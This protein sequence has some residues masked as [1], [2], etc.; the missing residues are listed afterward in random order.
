[1]S[2]TALLATITSPRKG[3]I[4]ISK[5]LN[6]SESTESHQLLECFKNAT[7][8]ELVEAQ[9]SL[10]V[11]KIHSTMQS[12]LQRTFSFL[13]ICVY[14]YVYIYIMYVCLYICLSQVLYT[15]EAPVGINLTIQHEKSSRI[16]KKN[17][18]ECPF[19]T[20]I[21]HIKKFQPVSTNLSLRFFLS[22]A[23]LVLKLSFL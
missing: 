5:A 17:I 23:L 9:Y 13:F 21:K 7:M 16:I 2:G 15:I 10:N 22:N 18:C 1:M 6:C 19:T 20:Y 11:R 14:V 8:E 4:S 3:A 12:T